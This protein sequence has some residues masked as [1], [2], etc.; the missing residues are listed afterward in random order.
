MPRILYLMHIDWHWIWQRPQALAATLS[1]RFDISVLYRLNPY[2]SQ[3]SRNPH[4]FSCLPLV[5]IP[6]RLFGSLSHGINKLYVRLMMLLRKP[7]VL[8]VTY[9][10]L[11]PVLPL[12]ACA[13][14]VVVYDC[15]D[16]PEGFTSS[17]DDSARISQQENRLLENADLVI[18]SSEML[19]E[20]IKEKSPRS[21][22]L[23]VRNGLSP[24]MLSAAEGYRHGNSSGQPDGENHPFVEL[25]YFGTISEW[26]DWNLLLS[27]LNRVP[28]LRIHLLGP[29]E[30]PPRHHHERLYCHPPVPHE[31][32]PAAVQDYDAFIMPF[33]INA[34]TK[35]V[36]PVKLYEYLATGKPVLSVR[37]PEVERFS[38]YVHFFSSPTECLDLVG[39]LKGGKL[40]AAPR[41]D[42]MAFLEQNT[43]EKRTKAVAEELIQRIGEKSSRSGSCDT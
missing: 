39:Q 1:Q 8:W 29:T 37:Y 27:L 7:D 26:M 21:N 31:Q 25:C 5:P 24:E 40:R 43:W 4:R 33:K 10:D 22:T 41:D 2:R 12:K 38:P 32:L 15:M 28:E 36:D 35:G 20:R 11:L 13:Q 17:P 16:N 3:L 19:L 9:P 30:S 23:L 14:C 42:I 34:L 18:C 6:E